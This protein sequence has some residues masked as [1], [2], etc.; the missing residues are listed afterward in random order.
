MAKQNI[1]DIQDALMN[2]FGHGIAANTNMTDEQGS[3]IDD[4]IE[5]A[6]QDIYDVLDTKKKAKSKKNRS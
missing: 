4:I 1:H 6:A 2:G 5:K 3:K